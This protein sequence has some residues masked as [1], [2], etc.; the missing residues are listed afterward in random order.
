MVRGLDYY[1]GMVFE[2]KYPYGENVF[3][4]LGGGRYD[5]VISELG[6]KDI[7]AV[8]YACGIERILSIMKEE[9][10]EIITK[11]LSEIF[12]L[13]MSKKRSLM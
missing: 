9:D 5:H 10:V 2:M 6:G 1:T 3:D 12:V 7:P 11:P 8:G 13:G 4:I